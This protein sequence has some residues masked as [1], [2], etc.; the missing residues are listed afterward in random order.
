M[1]SRLD[2]ERG[3]IGND[4]LLAA[5]AASNVRCTR[6]RCRGRA[7]ASRL[8]RKSPSRFAASSTSTHSPSTRKRSHQA[9]IEQEVVF[10][11]RGVGIEQ[12]LRL[13]PLLLGAQPGREDDHTTGP[14][15]GDADVHLPG[16]VGA[17]A[18][19]GKLDVTHAF[20]DAPQQQPLQL[21]H[22]VARRRSPRSSG[23]GCRPPPPSRSPQ[24]S[25]SS[26]RRP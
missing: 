21:L 22:V 24:R 3:R 23:R 13:L 14:V 5:Y 19:E 4:A 6:G 8:R 10:V 9:H 18:A 15:G 1:S 17:V 12:R 2:S 16:H 11:A 7:P 20:A 26:R 25:G